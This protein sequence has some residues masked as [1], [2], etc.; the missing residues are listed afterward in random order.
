MTLRI[1]RAEARDVPSL[2]ALIGELARYELSLATVSEADLLRDGFGP[3]P[4]FFAQVAR[5]D[6]ESVG[7]ALYVLT[8]STYRGAPVLFLEDLFVRPERRCAG[9]GLALM[10]VLAQEAVRLGC[11]RFAWEVL[12]WNERAIGFY[13]R[14]G[15][16]FKKDRVM[17]WLHGER[18]R[19]LA[20]AATSGVSI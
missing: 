8:Y 12:G 2:V 11:A 3:E 1:H 4:R 18:L 20:S 10:R 14:L 19:E 16:D 13:R 7:F 17:T 15:A 5:V 9:I 6:E